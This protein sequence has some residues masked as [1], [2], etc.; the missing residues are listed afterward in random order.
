MNKFKS[1]KVTVEGHAN[2]MSGT[3][4]E[5]EGTNVALY[6][7]G[8]KQLSKERADFVRKQLIKYGVDS[9]RLSAV[10]QGG[11]QPIVDRT[12]KANNWKN[13]RVEFIL[14]K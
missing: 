4:A 14:N 2:S 8:L 1:Y 3:A 7:P 6:G 9:S 11:S 13:R 12:D 5:E 10:G